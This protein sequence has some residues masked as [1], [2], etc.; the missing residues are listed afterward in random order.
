MGGVAALVLATLT[1]GTMVLAP[2]AVT[3]EWAN[4][5]P[6]VPHGTPFEIQMSVGDAAIRYLFALLAGPALGL[7]LGAIAAGSIAEPPADHPSIPTDP[8]SPRTEVAY[9]IA[10]GNGAVV[11]ERAPDGGSTQLW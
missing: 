2:H 4:P 8:K 5:D 9:A 11:A 1:I 3:L 7:M 10:P 6:R